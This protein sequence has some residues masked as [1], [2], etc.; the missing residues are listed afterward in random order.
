MF[1]RGIWLFMLE[2]KIYF[3]TTM[4][5]HGV[6]RPSFIGGKLTSPSPTGSGVPVEHFAI[7]VG[8]HERKR[9][10]IPLSFLNHLDF[11]DL[12]CQAE[13]EYRFHQPTGGLTIP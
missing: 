8:E 9:F 2:K 6:S 7:Y 13:E 11:Q 12:L 10:V 3:I 4:A 5:F 1:L